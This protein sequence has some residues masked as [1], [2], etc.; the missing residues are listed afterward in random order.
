MRATMPALRVPS[1]MIDVPAE[2]P[3]LPIIRE[4]RADVH[5]L[6]REAE[7]GKEAVRHSVEHQQK[8]TV[9]S[10]HPRVIRRPSVGI[11]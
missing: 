1:Q 11:D 3:Q 5:S 6:M 7:T 10:T 4:M 2:D 9:P 8:T